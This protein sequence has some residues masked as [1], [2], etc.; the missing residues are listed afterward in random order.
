MSSKD[1]E[2]EGAESDF[3]DD[4][5]NLT[6]SMVESSKKKKMKKFDFVTKDGNH[7]HF[8]KE[9][10][11]DQKRI[12]ESVKADAAK[13]EVE[14]RKEECINLLGVDVVVTVKGKMNDIASAHS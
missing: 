9:Q 11:K 2:E 5:I 13:Q 6:G 7:V 10:I 14:A 12:E 8:T 1:V 3:G 4:T